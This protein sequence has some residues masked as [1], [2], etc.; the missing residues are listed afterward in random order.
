MSVLS[1]WSIDFLLIILA[2]GWNIAQVRNWSRT[3]TDLL[4][5][6]SFQFVL[7]HVDNLKQRW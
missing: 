7:V 3:S 6:E 4:R 5:I 2:A 1:G